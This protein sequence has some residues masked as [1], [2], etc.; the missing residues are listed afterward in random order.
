MSAHLRVARLARSRVRKSHP[1]EL[2]GQP[3]DRELLTWSKLFRRSRELYL[4]LGGRFE[5]ALVTTPR[6]LSSAI[7]LEPRIEYS[8]TERELVWAATDP[9]E[10]RTGSHFQEIRSYTT[11]LFHEQNHRILWK[12]LPPPPAPAK[13]KPAARDGDEP[14]G[15]VRRYLH[16]AE[17]LVIASDMALADELGP[18]RSGPLY[19]CG[20]I[21]NPGSEARKAL[22]PR[23]YRNYLHVIAYVTYLLLELN[24][25]D[26]IEP[27]LA[28]LFPQVK[29]RIRGRAWLR[30]CKIDQQFLRVTNPFWQIRYG[31]KVA[32]ALRR[33]REK[34]TPLALPAEAADTLAFYLQCEHWLERL[35]A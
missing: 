21:Y 32:P 18:A 13:R 23:D 26:E 30:A 2:P 20:S 10:A 28:P 16:L 34:E 15:P 14:E 29:P 6:T 31:A 4:G 22:S 5:A 33:G 11:S 17:A 35:G 12:T 9:A 7:L 25:P 27:W 24:E 3:F 8:P 19:D 1:L